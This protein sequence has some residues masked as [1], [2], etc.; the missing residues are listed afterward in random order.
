MYR[1][2][3][4]D[5]YTQRVVY[6]RVLIKI[7]FSM[8]EVCLDPETN[9]MPY[10]NNILLQRPDITE[11]FWILMDNDN[12]FQRILGEKDKNKFTKQPVL[13]TREKWNEKCFNLMS[14]SKNKKVQL[15]LSHF[16]TSL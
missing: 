8:N 7:I 13:T 1:K 14:G 2:I 4:K 12:F 15:V 9:H 11:S 3:K 5:N 10:L 6:Y 16:I